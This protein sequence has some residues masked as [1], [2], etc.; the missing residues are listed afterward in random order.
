MST[1]KLLVATIVALSGA[2]LLFVPLA[3]ARTDE[4][5]Q[6]I[7]TNWLPEWKVTG[8]VKIKEPVKLARFQSLTEIIVPPVEPHET[9]RLVDAGTIDADGFPALVLSLHGVVK[10]STQRKGHVGAILLPEQSSIQEA[11]DERGLVHFALRAESSEID[12]RTIYFASAD[13]HHVLAFPSY[14]VLLYNTTDKTVTAN[15]FAYLT[16]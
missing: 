5:T 3:G 12:S 15:V 7:V 11:F 4:M 8:E 16:Q 14:R 10:G 9:T 2:T 6:V 1:R 13:P